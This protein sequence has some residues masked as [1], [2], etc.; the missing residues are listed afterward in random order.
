MLAA[1]LTVS[2]N[3]ASVTP[4]SSAFCPWKWVQY[5]HWIAA[6]ALN[7]TRAFSRAESYD[8]SKQ[9]IPDD[10]L[11]IPDDPPAVIGGWLRER[12]YPARDLAQVR[13]Y[14]ASC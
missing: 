10:S 12:R 14:V 6:A 11:E 2:A 8:V 9:E 3:S 5:G 7:P 13:F 1:R 4:S